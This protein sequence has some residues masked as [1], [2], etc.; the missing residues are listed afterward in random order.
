MV[1]ARMAQ[2]VSC[3]GV[4]RDIFITRYCKKGAAHERG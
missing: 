3:F 1:F 4:S 2:D